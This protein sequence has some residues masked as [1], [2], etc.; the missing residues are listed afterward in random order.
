MINDTIIAWNN[1]VWG[2]PLLFFVLGVG[3]ITTGAL[4]MVQIRE[5]YN[6]W[7]LMLFSKESKG[8]GDMTP[9]QAFI[10][11]LSTSVGNGSIAGMATAIYAGGPGAAFWIFIFGILSMAIRFCEVFLSNYYAPIMESGN[12]IG[13]PMI[14]LQKV[15]GGK[16]L[17][18]TF[19]WFLLLYGFISGNAIQANSI[20]IGCVRILPLEPVVIATVLFLFI[21][22]V[23]LGGSKRI[24]EVSDY[25]V[26]FKVLMFFSTA[27][28]I[29]AY[30]YQAL[31]HALYLIYQGAFDPKA[32][33][34]GATGILMQH[35]MRF[36]LVRSINATE[37]GLGTAGVLF[38]GTASKQPV[39]NGIL[40]M[41]SVFISANLVCFV[42]ALIIIMSG[43]WN[44]G[45]TSLDL[46][47]SAYETVFGAS[48]GWIV[49]VLAVIFGIGVLVAY[50][51]ITRACWLFITNGRWSRAFDIL[52][53]ACTFFGAMTHVEF[54]WNASDL[55]NAG[56]L[57]TNLFGIIWLLPIIRKELKLYQVSK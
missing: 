10:N 57:L 13:G 41:L 51:Y 50:A 4:R 7:Y 56:L 23:I 11:A 19:A 42:I 15:P 32:I 6:A 8:Q 53:C 35:A 30:H 3:I 2:W 18:Y 36:G 55:I 28:I 21:S 29:L 33:A 27:V 5:F 12:T 38:G 37:A 20:R 31:P 52:F 16:F 26:P 45:Q 34:G 47:I 46:T 25:I 54:V 40:S 14:Y 48:G 49:T 9:F 39:K 24:V 17:A 22:Y 44:N 43:V 1:I